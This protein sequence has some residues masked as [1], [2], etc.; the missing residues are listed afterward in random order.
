MNVTV[1]QLKNIIHE[2]VKKSLLKEE[3][4]SQSAEYDDILN[5]L[6]QFSART[7]SDPVATCQELLEDVTEYVKNGEFG[8][9]FN[10]QSEYSDPNDWR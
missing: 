10:K 4:F 8:D 7:G 9:Q 3:A 5:L 1:K 2:E 6:D